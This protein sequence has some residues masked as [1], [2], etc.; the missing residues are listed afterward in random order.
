MRYRCKV[1]TRVRTGGVCKLPSKC[2]TSLEWLENHHV[3]V[4]QSLDKNFSFGPP[5]VQGCPLQR[6]KLKW[7]IEI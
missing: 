5:E 3:N 4:N 6:I 2:L 7:Q 1:V